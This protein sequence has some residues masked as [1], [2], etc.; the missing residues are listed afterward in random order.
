VTPPGSD[1]SEP[2][3]GRPAPL[4]LEAAVAIIAARDQEIA[5]LKALVEELSRKL[6]ENSSN[7]H[8]PPSSDGPGAAS[9]G[10]RRPWKGS[11]R[12]RGGQKGH[13]GSFRCLL[14]EELVTEKVD[15]YPAV[16]DGCA[17]DLD[18]KV[19][20]ATR[21]PRRYQLLDLGPTGGRLVKE[22]RR[23]CLGCGRC[24]T[25]TWAPW[26]P[27]QV[28]RE[29]FGPRLRAA[30]ASLTGDHHLS[31]RGAQQ[32]IRELFD[33]RVSLGALSQSEKQVSD[34]LAAPYGEVEKAVQEA[35]VKHLDATSWLRAGALRS[36]F[37]ISTPALVFYRVLEDGKLD[38][39]ATLFSVVLGVLVSDRAGAFGFWS[40]KWRQ[41][42][43]AHLLRKF[44]SFSERDG[45]AG[46]LGRDLIACTAL[47]FDYW[48]A[49][50]EG[51]LTRAE[52]ATWMRPL[53]QQFE[54]LV[55]RG[56]SLSLKGVTGACKN[57]LAHQDAWWTFVTHE[58]VPPT[59]N[60]AERDLRP[61]VLWRKRSFGCQSERG[62]RFA[63]RMMTVARTLRRRGGRAFDYLVESLVARAAGAGPPP[64]LAP[65]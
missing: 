23:H 58:G 2:R 40:M 8:L 43:W 35:P 30:M 20:L 63:E 11:G 17:R 54:A 61:F 7:S 65:A 13:T 51:R 9:K 52:L 37:T 39:V 29:A 38:S 10:L 62:E 27:T 44:V 1:D 22:T 34:A 25:S 5:G 60:L 59:N 16:C 3:D 36:L 41:V 31:R 33:I 18:P 57:L 55:K 26:D 24:G 49:F 48:H 53:Q 4:S 6:G 14:P 15:L 64:L 28:P 45:P 56:A 42:C 12:K 47:L 19:D 21:P 32:V 46:A 50:R